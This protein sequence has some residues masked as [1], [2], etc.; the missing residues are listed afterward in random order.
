MDAVSTCLHLGAKRQRG[1]TLIELMV[2]LLL[3]LVVVAAASGLFLTNKRVYASTET[4]NRIQENSRVAFELMSRDVREAGG[5]PCGTSSR[6][7]N[8]LTTAGNEWWLGYE[9]GIRGYEAGD[10]AP[11][12]TRAPGTDAVDLHI[13]GGESISVVEH[14]NP[15]A[16]LRVTDATGISTGDL[17]MVCNTEISMVFIAT[18][19][20]SAGG[21]IG[22]QHNGGNS[23][24]GVDNCG[25]EFQFQGCAPG[26]S[27]S[28][29]Y[30]FLVND[31]TSINPNCARY[32]QNPAQVVSV[33]SFRWYVA[34]NGRGGHSLYRAKLV[35]RTAGNT[36]TVVDSIEVAEGITNLQLQYRTVGDT[37]WRNAS[38][39]TDWAAVNA[40]KVELVAEG[41]EG[42]LGGGYLQGTDGDVLSRTTSHVVALRNREGVL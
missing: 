9:N 20:N 4:L 16:N 8:Q 27:S 7:A 2:A 35:N 39:L 6:M 3:G 31:L 15:G 1:A 25:Q 24:F 19:V 40:V 38:P 14:D 21:G 42:A 17:L 18:G 37:T 36:P 32:S 41:T 34:Q 12:T 11:G 33:Q 29:G 23:G 22:I 5:N 26:A 13:P 10:V 30:C 28:Y